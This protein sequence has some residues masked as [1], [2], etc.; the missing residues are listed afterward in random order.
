MKDQCPECRRP[1]I[2]P[3]ED[4]LLA[5]R[6]EKQK[7]AD[8]LALKKKSAA[9]HR[10]KDYEEKL[11]IKKTLGA[12]TPA[13]KA[14]AKH[15]DDPVDAEIVDSVSPPHV[16]EGRETDATVPEKTPITA[17][18]IFCSFCGGQIPATS[19]HCMHCGK[20]VPNL[21]FPDTRPISATAA[22]P[23][24]AQK[25]QVR[26]TKPVEWLL[27]G[28]SIAFITLCGLCGGFGGG[29]SNTSSPPA[30]YSRS[31]HPTSPLGNALVISVSVEDF[32]SAANG[33]PLKRLLTTWKNTGDVEI[34]AVEADITGYDVNGLVVYT[35]PAYT[36][37]AEWNDE[38]GILPGEV[39]STPY[40]QGHIMPADVAS[41]KAVIT[42]ATSKGL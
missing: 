20:Q 37:F 18:M 38:D 9:E 24:A 17:N 15:N 1:F 19:K 21:S 5:E 42:L 12:K 41:A 30:S 28:T 11:Q 2:V 16:S 39:F 31:S 34:R 22:K 40:D 10:R 26:K 35:A 6:A 8:L 36:I 32:V 4:R 23:T 25:T 14:P 13:H 7:Q 3:G 27:I 29:G 33:A